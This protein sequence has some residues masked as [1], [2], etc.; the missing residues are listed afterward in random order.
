[1]TDSETGSRQ[2]ARRVESPPRGQ[3]LGLTLLVVLEAPPRARRVSGPDRARYRRRR[4]GPGG[5][6]RRRR[7]PSATA[8]RT[9]PHRR[10]PPASGL[11]WQQ[12]L[13]RLAL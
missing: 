8:R 7:R 12:L 2:P 9:S 1:M 13:P 4:V 6:H 3:R 11:V 10:R 5:R